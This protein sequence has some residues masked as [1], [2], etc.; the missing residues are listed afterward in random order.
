M[1]AVVMFGIFFVPGL[2]VGLFV[3][4]LVGKFIANLVVRSFVRAVVL[5]LCLTPVMI[6]APDVHGAFIL[7]AFWG[8]PLLISSGQRG[9][10]VYAAAAC[11]LLLFIWFIGWNMSLDRARRDSI[12]R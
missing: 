8:L 3:C 7:P 5:S 6:S 4:F 2:L 11:G 12:A 1:D 10:W 9:A